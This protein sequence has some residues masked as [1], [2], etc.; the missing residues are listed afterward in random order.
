MRAWILFAV[1]FVTLRPPAV[2]QVRRDDSAQAIAGLR[3]IT[4]DLDAAVR[5]LN[6]DLDREIAMHDRGY[7]SK[8]GF[9]IPAAD[10]DLITGQAD[11]VQTAMRKLVAA[12]IL[13]ARSPGSEPAPV[14]DIEQIQGLIAEARDRI[15]GGNEA[16]KR[17]LVVSAKELNSRSDAEQQLRRFELRRARNAAGDAARKALVALPIDLPEADSPEEQRD[18]AWD[19]LVA[20]LKKGAASALIPVRFETGKRIILINEH[21]CRITFSDSGMEDRQ[22]RHL[23]YQEQWLTRTGSIAR[24]N[25]TGPSGIVMWMRWAVALN[26]G[27]GQHT[28]LRRYETHEFQGNF[29]ELYELHQPLPTDAAVTTA[30]LTE[31]AAPPSV[32]DIASAV[33]SLEGAG[34]DLQTALSA[35]HRIAGDAMS[36]NDPLAG[37]TE[38]PAWLQQKLF[39]IRGHLAGVNAVLDAEQVVRVA[40]ERTGRSIR[41]L[42]ALTAF[43]NA[44]T[45]ESDG[46]ARASRALVDLETRA[47]MGVITMGALKKEALETL[48]PDLP[49]PEVQLPALGKN[50]IVRIRRLGASPAG[51][52]GVRFRQEVWLLESPAQGQRQVRRNIVTLDLDPKAWRETLVSSDA[53]FYPIDPGELLEEIYDENAAQ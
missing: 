51:A 47:D 37:E 11:V 42:E 3:Q 2:A 48:P 34:R 16:L 24:T 45:L 46:R 38:L 10:S 13:A 19:A 6:S 39:A 30:K 4:T 22:G 44:N 17:M 29:N 41:E 7:R 31:G 35:F 14:A 53:N 43:V 49:S 1:A 15:D 25:G 36:H 52:G 5:H 21:F 28:L 8:S 12:R 23:F 9:R 27:N 26:T 33:T 20:S 32:A 40:V 50:V 18:R